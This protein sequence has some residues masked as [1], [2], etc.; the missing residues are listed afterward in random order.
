MTRIP[1][2]AACVAIRLEG[3]PGTLPTRV[4][5]SLGP[6]VHAASIACCTRDR[7]DDQLSEESAGMPACGL[8]TDK[9]IV[10]GTEVFSCVTV[11]G[12]TA[13]GP[14]ATQTAVRLSDSPPAPITPPVSIE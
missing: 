11:L 5:M 6:L 7:N 8:F 4:L 12:G 1:P 13:K 3:T 14:A 9:A 2:L 10:F